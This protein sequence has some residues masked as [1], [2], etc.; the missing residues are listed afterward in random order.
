MRDGCLDGETWKEWEELGSIRED[1]GH[2]SEG[3]KGRWLG[4]DTRGLLERYLFS[5]GFG[6]VYT[7]THFVRIGCCVRLFGALSISVYVDLYIYRY[8][9]QK[10]VFLK[11]NS[12]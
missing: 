9:L 3:G 10:Y 2:L 1:I 4:R 5:L 11:K 12:S 6:I 8:I 7:Q